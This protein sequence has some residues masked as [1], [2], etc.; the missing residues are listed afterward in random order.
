M[1]ALGYIWFTVQVKMKVA[2]YVSALENGELLP[3]E[4]SAMDLISRG[5]L[6][7]DDLARS[8]VP[9]LLHKA[10]KL[11]RGCVLRPGGSTGEATGLMEL[12]FLLGGALN[13]S[14]LQHAFGIS[15]RH[16]KIA[17]PPLINPLLPYFFAVEGEA[18]QEA[19]STTLNLLKNREHYMLVRDEVVYAR[20][21]NAIYGMGTWF[22]VV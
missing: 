18:L 14:A 19:V 20:S 12:G 1:V 4:S 16:A 8:L 6:R 9:H 17:A 13:N 22:G 21:F 7:S 11:R 2:A 3:A 5:A 10:D 15:K